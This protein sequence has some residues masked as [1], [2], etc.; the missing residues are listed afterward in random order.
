MN[1]IVVEHYPVLQLPED[2]REGLKPTGSVRVTVETERTTPPTGAEI[3]AQLR[4]EKAAARNGDGVT[5]EE[6]VERIRRL[7][8]EWED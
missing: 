3:V 8:N 1:K 2:L 4:A 7:R 6:A 5:L